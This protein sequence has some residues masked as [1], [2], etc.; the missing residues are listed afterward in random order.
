MEK[1]YNDPIYK[2]AQDVII[3]MLEIISDTVGKVLNAY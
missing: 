2:V 3:K 1:H